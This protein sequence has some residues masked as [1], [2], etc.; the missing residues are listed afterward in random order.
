MRLGGAVSVFVDIDPLT[1]TMDPLKVEEAI[2]PH[3]RAIIPVH[4]YGYPVDLNLI[5]AVANRY[6]VRVIEYCA[7]SHGAKYRGR[8]TGSL[9]HLG[10]FSF[11]PT[12]NLGAIGDSGMVVTDD[13]ELAGPVRLLRQYGW[14][15]RYLSDIE[16]TNSQLDELQAAILCV[17][18]RHLDENNARRQIH[19]ARY[20]KL[21]KESTL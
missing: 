19:A 10:C 5:L 8:R 13:P 1:M 17:R 14:Q 20:Q 7:Q 12:K 11:Y 18:R 9:G 2:T 21:L 6:G 16:G 15:R 4:L 3:T